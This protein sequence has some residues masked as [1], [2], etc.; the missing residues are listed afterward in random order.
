MMPGQRNRSECEMEAGKVRSMSTREVT[1]E[2][3]K[4]GDHG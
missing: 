4:A 2:G 3:K 1:A